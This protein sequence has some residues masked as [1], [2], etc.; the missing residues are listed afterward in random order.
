MALASQEP[1][2]LVS[3][4]Q[5]LL[6]L[7]QVSTGAMALVGLDPATLQPQWS[8]KAPTRVSWAR[9]QLSGPRHDI[10]LVKTDAFFLPPYN[11][12]IAAYNASNGHLLWQVRT[13]M[14]CNSPIFIKFYFFL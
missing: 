5:R 14:M 10:V 8:T 7:F 1:N 2:I 9:P 12:S 3:P 6:V 13:G 11:T 4:R